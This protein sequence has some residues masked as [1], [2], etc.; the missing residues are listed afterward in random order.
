[1]IKDHLNYLM[2]ILKNVFF[3]RPDE[4]KKVEAILSK[5]GIPVILSLVLFAAIISIGALVTHGIILKVLTVLSLFL[6]LFSIYFFRDPERE[7]PPGEN[8]IVSPAD[9]KVILIEQIPEEDVF[10]TTVQKV[11]IFMSVF[12]VHV[13]RIPIDG[14]VT[15]FNY[16]KGKFHQA[17]KDD[18]SY[19]NE[20]TIIV[21]ENDE[22]KLLFVQIAGILAK[23]IVCRIREGWNV[24]QGD[25]FGMIKFGSRVDMLLPMEV[26][27][28]IKLNQKVKAGATIIGHYDDA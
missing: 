22:I 27:L 2:K 23:R 4:N 1:M 11:S 13:N 7:I 3:N 12:D 9:G 19:E 17:F 25:R 6:V 26:K 16:Q 8:L 24:K 14:R 18:A 5:E 21:V 28:N 10:K 15:Y 20:R